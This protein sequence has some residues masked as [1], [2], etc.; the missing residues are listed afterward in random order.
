MKNKKEIENFLDENFGYN[1]KLETKAKSE[2]L[3]NVLFFIVVFILIFYGAKLTI[4]DFKKN[5]K[6]SESH[7][8]Y[9]IPFFPARGNIISADNFTLAENKFGFDLIIDLVILRSKREI[10]EETVNFLEQIGILKEEREIT[11]KDL[12]EKIKK[13]SQIILRNIGEEKAFL[14][15]NRQ[16]PS[17]IVIENFIRSYPYPEVFSHVLGTLKL[18]NNSYIGASGLEKSYDNFLLGSLGY[19]KYLRN[20]RGEIIKEIEEKGS[21]QGFHLKTTIN[22]RLQKIIFEEFE[23]FSKENEIKKGAIIFMDKDGRIL[24]LLSF[25]SFDNNL[26]TKFLTDK[27]EVEKLKNILQS[28]DSPLYN[29]ATLGIYLPGSTIKPLV[30]VAGLEL[31]KINKEDRILSTGKI[32]L[33]NPY[34]GKIY[35]FKDWKEGG[36]GL[37]NIEEAIKESVNTFFYLLGEKIGAE[38]ILNF[39]KKILLNQPTGIDIEEKSGFLPDKLSFLGDIFNISIGQGK[40][41]LTPLRLVLMMESLVLNKISRPF[42]VEKIIDNE[43]NVVFERKPEVI[44]DNIFSEKNLKIIKKGMELVVSEGFGKILIPFSV[45]GKTGTPQAGE[46]INGIFVGYFPREN[47][48]YFFVVLLENSKLWSLSAIRLTYNIL[49][50]AFKEGIF[51]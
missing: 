27:K 2:L 48:Q 18:E 26:F 34:S 6:I 36:H 23:K 39:Y 7:Y 50:R 19:K 33:K 44:L 43:G 40:I 38:N 51:K 25:P 8:Y 47:P 41:G 31:G 46:S 13:Q 5:I 45:A 16:L 35:V 4:L 21:K 20:A 10:F 1:F 11:K 12:E 14:I 37:V 15:K 3:L 30:G 22:F 9:T 42:L 28:K 29:R 17:L 24:S 49:N 32:L